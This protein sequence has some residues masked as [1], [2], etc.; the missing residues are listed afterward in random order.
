MNDEDRAAALEEIERGYRELGAVLD[1]LSADDMLRPNTVGHW[2]GKDVLAHLA[3]WDIEGARHVNA[4]DAGEEDSIPDASDFDA[5]NE[6]QVSKT[7]D[8]SLDQVRAYFEA[9]HRDFVQVV[10][11]SASITPG[12]AI[13]LSSHHYGEHIDQFRSMK[14][15]P[16]G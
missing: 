15:A 16:T 2:N 14:S 11:T 6:E 10:R 3:A 8:M 5:W 7:R 13:G 4:R 12:F 1:S 9:A